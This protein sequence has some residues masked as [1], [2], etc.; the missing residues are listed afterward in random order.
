MLHTK[1]S[2]TK[3]VITTIVTDILCYPPFICEFF[4]VSSLTDSKCKL[5]ILIMLIFVDS[6]SPLIFFSHS[7]VIYN[8]A[9]PFVQDN[10]AGWRQVQNR[11]S[12]STDHA[13]CYTLPS[14]AP[15]LFKFS[16]GNFIST[17][18]TTQSSILP[19][20]RLWRFVGLYLSAKCYFLCWFL[21]SS[22]RQVHYL[23]NGKSASAL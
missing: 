16:L 5:P 3:S 15:A 22:L 2:K 9:K 7:V 21:S 10:C 1:P 19:E 17:K 4:F 20:Y 8:R 23:R 12:K 13:S 11:S 6:D 14:T 18:R